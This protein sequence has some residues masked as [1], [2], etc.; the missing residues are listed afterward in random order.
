MPTPVFGVICCV[1]EPIGGK[2]AESSAPTE[3][4]VRRA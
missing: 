2:H 3:A 1:A 4:V